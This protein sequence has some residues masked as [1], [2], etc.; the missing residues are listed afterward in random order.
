MAKVLRCND[1]MP[2]CPFEARGTEE[3]VLAKA[4]EH[5]Q[6]DHQI[7]ELTPEVVDKVKSAIR[8]E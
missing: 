5:A 2:G 4:A 3:E 1:V 8:D 6:K 7:R